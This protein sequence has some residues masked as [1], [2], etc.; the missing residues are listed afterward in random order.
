MR[1]A[2]AVASSVLLSVGAAGGATLPAG[3]WPSGPGPAPAAFTLRH[4]LDNLL[5]SAG[6]GFGSEVAT[7]GARV[8]VGA[9]RASDNTLQQ[10]SAALFDVVTGALLHSFASPL[11]PASGRFGAAVAIDGDRLAIGA[12]VSSRAFVYDAQGFQLDQTLHSPLTP[13]SER[14]GAGVA[15]GDGEVF[16]GAPRRD[17]DSTSDAGQAFR[18]IPPIPQPV[19]ILDNP[20]PRQSGGLGA[21]LAYDDGLLLASEAGAIGGFVQG[22]ACLFDVSTG[23]VAQTLA[24]PAPGAPSLM[25]ANRFCDAVAL[26]GDFAVVGD[27]GDDLNGLNAGAVVVFDKATGAVVR[28]FHSPDLQVGDQFG[29]AGATDGTVLA[30]GEPGHQ[31]ALGQVHVFDMLTGAL[32]QTIANPDPLASLDPLTAKSGSFGAALAFAGDTP[33]IEASGLKTAMPSGPNAVLM[34]R[35]GG[36]AFVYSRAAPT[37]PPPERPAPVPLP[38]PAAPLGAALLGLIGAARRRR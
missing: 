14:F 28:S 37:P 26:A 20:G 4:T 2:T 33:V 13:S 1:I 16:V 22:S 10:G 19:R 5:P 11:A 23:G 30:V 3:P 8:L 9:P 24:D 38:A 31:N 35:N 12:E 25:N 15:V 21:D 17:V 7:D 36:Q 6:N 29:E 34:P 27:P 32:L 18:F